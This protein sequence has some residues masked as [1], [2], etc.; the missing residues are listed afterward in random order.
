MQSHNVRLAGYQWIDQARQKGGPS[1]TLTSIVS[2][3]K[4]VAFLG[5]VLNFMNEEVG[6]WLGKYDGSCP[7]FAIP[8][9]RR[10]ALNSTEPIELYAA[11]VLKLRSFS[12]SRT[13]R[14]RNLGATLQMLHVGLGHPCTALGSYSSSYSTVIR[15]YGSYRTT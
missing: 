9:R 15:H 11:V 5:G 13:M 7:D 12:G 8:A 4:L 2:C 1:P 10:Q 6:L 3:S 14:K